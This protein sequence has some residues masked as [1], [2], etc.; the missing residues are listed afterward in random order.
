[1]PINQ[2]PQEFNF[3]DSFKKTIDEF[4]ELEAAA[5]EDYNRASNYDQDIQEKEAELG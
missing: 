3:G 2:E 5:Q 4:D 1:M